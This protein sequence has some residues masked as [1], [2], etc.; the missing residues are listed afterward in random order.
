MSLCN[1]N[2]F[3]AICVDHALWLKRNELQLSSAFQA[4]DFPKTLLDL[5][6]PATKMKV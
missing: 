3:D 2:Q 4:L 1:L 5:A 6:N